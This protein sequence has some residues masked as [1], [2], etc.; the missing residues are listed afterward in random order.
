[1]SI[2]RFPVAA[3]WTEP[4]ATRLNIFQRVWRRWF[5]KHNRANV[6]KLR[7]DRARRY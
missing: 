6:A 7:I 5:G 1:M 4:M 2:I 3:K